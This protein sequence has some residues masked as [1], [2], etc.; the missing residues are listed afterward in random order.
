[1]KQA[2]AGVAPPELS[3]VTSMT[4]W[5]SIAEYGLA[6]TLGRLYGIRAG[7]GFLTVG[8]LFMLLTIPL[9]LAMFFYSLIP[10]IPF[11]GTYNKRYALTNRRVIKQH[12]RLT[13]RVQKLW[14]VPVPMMH[15]IHSEIG[16]YVDLDRFDAIEVR[17][18]P[19]QEA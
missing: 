2:V 17:I 5:P 9:A 13:W 12:G 6:K 4:V 3:E 18:E 16:S 10:P 8:K 1:M 15:F 7:V 14:G 11:F 19:G